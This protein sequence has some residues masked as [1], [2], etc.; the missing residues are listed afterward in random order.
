MSEWLQGALG[1]LGC[2]WDRSKL[3]L[4]NSGVV[5]R[6]QRDEGRRGQVRWCLVSRE[7]LEEQRAQGSGV[8]R[9]QSNPGDQDRLGGAERQEGEGRE[10]PRGRRGTGR[11][12]EGAWSKQNQQ[13]EAEPRAG[14]RCWSLLCSVHRKKTLGFKPEIQ[15]CLPWIFFFLLTSQAAEHQAELWHMSMTPFW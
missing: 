10:G 5:E 13:L 4:E 3:P 7:V 9:G 6:L 15:N 14:T 12:P 8:Q 1:A 2:L 11:V